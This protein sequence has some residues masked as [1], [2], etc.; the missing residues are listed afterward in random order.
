VK[1]QN[2]PW[3]SL[4]PN[5]D[6]VIL[7][8]DGDF[9]RKVRLHLELDRAGHSTRAERLVKELQVERQASI[10][11][12]D[13]TSSDSGKGLDQDNEIALGSPP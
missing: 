9:H 13:P 11:A 10:A 8:F 5:E 2:Q 3:F 7:L 12:C 1:F 6:P 4:S